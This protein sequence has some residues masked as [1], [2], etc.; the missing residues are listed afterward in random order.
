MDSVFETV[1]HNKA[2]PAKIFVTQISRCAFH[3]HYDYEIILIL[4]G[5]V[6]VYCGAEPTTLSAG[7]LF[8]FNTK[9]VHGIQR[10]AEDNLILCLQFAPQLLESDMDL[11]QF[12]HHFYLSSTDDIYKPQLPYQHFRT[13]MV[14][15]ALTNQKA[16]ETTALRTY[17]LLLSFIADIIDNVQ[18]DIRRT[19]LSQNEDTTN[20]FCNNILGYIDHNLQSQNLAQDLCRN[21]GM[22]EKSLYRYLKTTLGLSF[23][24]LYDIVR[25]EKACSLLQENKKSI[26]IIWE[27]CGFSSEVS[28][29]RNFKKQMGVTPKEYRN[30]GKTQRITGSS[31]ESYD[32]FNLGE[33]TGLLYGILDA[34][35]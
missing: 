30:G 5:T 22:S 4:K 19:A 28:F 8:L 24:E 1:N 35:D 21:F 26:S 15:I 3:W 12:Y 10:T 13:G 16:T 14:K 7:D 27:L 17:S 11:Q 20:G 34:N 2:F 25:I 9:A 31:G 32:C 23:K 29:Y 33:A 6:T 18:F